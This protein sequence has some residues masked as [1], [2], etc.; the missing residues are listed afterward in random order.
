MAN[1]FDVAKYI[2]EKQGEMTA[3]KLQKLVYYSQAWH[4]VWEEKLLFKNQI[5]AW[6]NGPVAPSLYELHRG[7][8]LVN[9]TDIPSGLSSSLSDTEKACQYN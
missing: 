9:A 4:A 7:S 1:V 6:I 8:F 5:E 2:L 3:M